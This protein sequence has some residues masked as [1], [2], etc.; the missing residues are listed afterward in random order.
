VLD[1]DAELDSEVEALDSLEPEPEPLE[2]DSF[3]PESFDAPSFEPPSF[4]L[5]SFEPDSEAVDPLVLVDDFD[6]RESVMYQPLPLNTMPT[7]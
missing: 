2:P 6:D 1:V 7:G 4:E 3:D 5:P